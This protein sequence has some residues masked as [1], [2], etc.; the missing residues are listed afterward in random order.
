[1][2]IGILTGGGDCP[3][4]NA[5]IRSV[6]RTGTLKYDDEI[7][8]IENAFD[9]LLDTQLTR[10]LSVEDV[11][12]IIGQGGTI[13]GTTNRGDPFKYPVTENGKQVLKDLSDTVLRNIKK[14]GL[15]ALIVVGG[16]GTLAIAHELYK[17]GAP[18]IA[19]P[20]TIDN[21]LLGTDYT[22]G[23][24]TAATIAMESLDRLH[25]TAK[26]HHRAMVVE[27]MGRYAG[28]IALDAGV[29]GGAEVILIPEIPFTI[30]KVCT[31]IRERNE[32]R[33]FY[34][35]VVVAEGARP[36]GHQTMIIEKKEDNFGGMERIGGI[37]NWV[38]E[39]IQKH[40]GI[41]TRCVVLG[42]LQRGGA[43]TH[44]DRLLATRLGDFA[45]DLAHRKMFGMMAALKGK[46]IVAVDVLDAVERI[47]YVKPESD[48]VK[49]ASAM[50]IS[51]GN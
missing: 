10:P 29:T 1:M 22:V 41:E 48:A 16:D 47:R 39:S 21:D 24:D 34:S 44:F 12:G 32:A 23:F 40:S 35:L 45:V 6:V 17:L 13:L 14:L 33:K 46:S 30:D 19:V 49:T 31:A 43:P 8:G 28:W 15:E 50:G 3:G 4:L 42:H 11:R 7:I 37:G 2:K 27:V 5:V 25:T 20:K 38:A 36:A 9:G 51:F 18:V 26:S